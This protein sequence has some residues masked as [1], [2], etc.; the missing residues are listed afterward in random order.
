[1]DRSPGREKGRVSP[2]VNIEMGLPKDVPG[3][4]ACCQP[5]DMAQRARTDAQGAPP[6]HGEELVQGA[7]E[8]VTQRG[9]GASLMAISQT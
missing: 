8:P 1:M 4:A 2:C 9:C 6:E 7:L 5:Q 3:S